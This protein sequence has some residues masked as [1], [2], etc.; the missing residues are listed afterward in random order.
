VCVCVCVL[1]NDDRRAAGQERHRLNVATN[2]LGFLGVLPPG[3]PPL[4]LRVC[5]WCVCVCC[6][7][8]CAQVCCVCCAV[9][10]CAD[11]VT[12]RDDLLPSEILQ[13]ILQFLGPKELLRRVPP[14]NRHL[15]ELTNDNALWKAM[16]RFVALACVQNLHDFMTGAVVSLCCLLACSSYR[17]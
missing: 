9:L 5:A 1:L 16:C 17:E 7:C 3:K 2:S 11:G 8:A 15:N 12:S 6:E 4:S 14:L 13:H 10:C